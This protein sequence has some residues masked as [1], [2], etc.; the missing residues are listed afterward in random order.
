MQFFIVVQLCFKLVC[1]CYNLSIAVVP[2]VGNQTEPKTGL[3][4]M[5]IGTKSDDEQNKQVTYADI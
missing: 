4:R 3:N 1:T 5:T 2:I